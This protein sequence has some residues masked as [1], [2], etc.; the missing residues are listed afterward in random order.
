MLWIALQSSFSEAPPPES[1][2]TRMQQQHLSQ[3]VLHLLT[4]QVT[5]QHS[6]TGAR[7]ATSQGQ[8]HPSVDPGRLGTP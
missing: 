8:T 2:A 1:Y 3:Q 7:V 6:M 4:L 5:T